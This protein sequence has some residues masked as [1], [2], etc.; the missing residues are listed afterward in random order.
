MQTV[1]DGS[2]NTVMI[3]EAETTIPWTKPEDLIIDETKPLPKLGVGDGPT[4]NVAF[5]D[6]AV[7][8]MTKKATIETLLPFLTAGKG[9]TGDIS[10]LIQGESPRPYVPDEQSGKAADRSATTVEQNP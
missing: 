1:T 3:L 6:G 5:A 8:R 4:F 7:Y 2:S 9:D 10:K